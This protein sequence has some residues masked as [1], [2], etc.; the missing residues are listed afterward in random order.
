MCHN[1]CVPKPFTPQQLL[2]RA[3]SVPDIT[4]P[5]ELPVCAKRAEIAEAIKRSQVVIVSG[6]TGS[7]KTT[8]LPKICLELGRGIN[9][10]IGHTQPRRIAA[11]AVAERISRELGT[12]TGGIVGYQV[13]FNE[14]VSENTLIK[15]MTDGIL[16]AEIQSDP[17]LLRYDTIIIDEAHERSLNI[18]F[19][20]GYLANLLPKRKDLKLIVTSATIDSQKFASHFGLHRY[21][22]TAGSKAPVINVTGRT[23]PVEIRYRPPEN[24]YLP[25]DGAAETQTE[26]H[27]AAD[28]ISGILEAARELFT[29]SQGDILVFLSGEGEIRETEKAFRD[30]LK[31]RYIPPGGTSDIPGAVEVL[32]LFS[33]LSSAEQHRIFSRPKHRR[34]I[35]STNI[36]ET[37]LTVP[38]IRC[39]IDPGTARISRFSNKTKV[40]RLP[41]EPISQA[42]AN[43][44]SGR[45]GRVA[46]GIAIRLYSEQDFLSRPAFTE[47]EILRTSLSSVILRMTALNLGDAKHFP[48]IDPPDTRAV[49]AGTQLL[50]EIGAIKTDTDG[51]LRLTRTGKSLAGLPIDPRLGKMLLSAGENG[52]AGEVLILVAA[53]SVQDMRERPAEFKAQSDALH[54]RFT[55]KNSDFLAYLNLW[56]YLRVQQ[57]ELSGAAF[58]R[59]CKAEYLHF[60]RFREWQDVVTQLKQAAKQLGIHL[61]PITLPTPAQLRGAAAEDTDNTQHRDVIRA[62]KNVGEYS[63]AP[64]ADAIHRSLLTGLLSNIGH[65]DER[66]HDYGGARGTHF[67]IWPGSGLY[68]H[69]PEWVIAA[70]LVETSRLFARTVAKIDP[71]WIERAAKHLVKRSYSEPFWSQRMGAAMVCEKVTLY[72]ITLVADR[73]TLLSKTGSEHCREIARELFIR[74]ALVQN[75]WRTHHK[76]AAHNR[77]ALEKA[78]ETEARR[79]EY[80][81]VADEEEQFSFFDRI[82]PA[83]IVSARHFD[84]WWKKERGKNPDLLNF[85][86]EFLLGE[87]R[88][89]PHDFPNTWHQGE[90][91]LPIRYGFNPGKYD[92]GLTI[93]IP[94]TLLGQIKDTGF[95]WLVPGMLEELTLGTIRA[96]PK[97][98]R[99]QLVPAPD[100]ARQIMACL[101]PWEEAV[102]RDHIPFRKAFSDAVFRLRGVTVDDGQ[103]Q[104][105]NL[106]E[107]L[108]ISFLI[109]SERGAVLDQGDS[110]TRLQRALAP[111]T[112]KAVSSVV[113]SAVA[114][115]MEENTG[116]GG[117]KTRNSSAAEKTRGAGRGGHPETKPQ[118]SPAGNLTSW[119]Q[120]PNGIIPEVLET[121]GPGNICVRGYPAL[122]AQNTQE[123][124]IYGQTLRLPTRKSG[125]ALQIL[126]DAQQRRQVHTNGLVLLLKNELALPDGR[127]TSRWTGAQSLLLGGSPYADTADLV[128]DLQ[129]Q[130]VRN[131]AARAAKQEKIQL[132]NVRTESEYESLRKIIREK[133]E[134]ET[135]RLA[136]ICTHIFSAQA[137]LES[138]LG[139]T[140]APLLAP[141]AGEIREQ[142]ANLIFPGFIFATPEEYLAQIPRYLRGAYIRLEKAGEKLFADDAFSLQIR[143]TED[144]ICDFGERI[145]PGVCDPQLLRKLTRARWML[146]EL[147]ISLFAQQLGT[148]GKVSVQRIRKLLE[149]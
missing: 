26:K 142:I 60:L 115:A 66:K 12:Q 77:A 131:T 72:G 27:G 19:L 64:A 123:R 62:V 108:K 31:T 61:K 130:A 14:T 39:V 2:M 75:Q 47:P 68:K 18:D 95:D 125:V 25:D 116:P 141:V 113:S 78:H 65:R 74:H 54:A 122:V 36:A 136:Q 13:R 138:L 120:I 20:L 70:E 45:C 58:R 99:K 103:W 22:G 79:R 37:S 93:E 145:V 102:H 42:S 110:L 129:L 73:K 33:R 5:E 28:Q 38:G 55:D 94:V 52:C 88:A 147:R 96:L 127:I 144:L 81:L 67:V 114:H 92:D 30:A 41:I 21:G 91:T 146:E 135:Y 118:I 4:Y 44:R 8:Q 137:E 59:M 71:A 80:A 105:T 40:Q 24:G 98:V 117:S 3:Q 140:S 86:E 16:L 69:N 51:K 46:D 76:F 63:D 90:I 43:Q 121:P 50:E 1:I 17:L 29:A 97:P 87:N 119:K 11:R 48:F 7:G 35:L 148:K 23:Y 133:S 104:Q 101:P 83:H 132:G 107:H 57:R 134:D 84:A 149:S 6:E 15:L 49:R 100:A 106:P 34:I 111:Q 143:E 56:R 109:R 85:T 124:R 82:I 53:M 128:A 32:P 112:Q 10:L 139:R 126:A 89:A 9:G